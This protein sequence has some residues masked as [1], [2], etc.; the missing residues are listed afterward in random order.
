M[1]HRRLVVLIVTA[2]AAV[3]VSSCSD[4]SNE[5]QAQNDASTPK[6]EGRHLDLNVTTAEVDH[7]TQDYTPIVAEV[8]D[9]PIPFAGSDGQTHLAYELETINFTGGE[10]TIEQ[11]E[12]LDADTGDVIDTLDTAEVATRLQPGGLR[13]PA[14][15]PAPSMMATVFLHVTFDEAGEVPDRLVHWLSVQAEAAPPDQQ[16]ITEEVGRPRLTAVTSSW[17]DPR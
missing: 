3:L 13:D 7:G 11:L 12:V 9:A 2:L 4:S 10:T 6:D 8:P 17:S 1:L 5:E 16:Q 15:A 14:D